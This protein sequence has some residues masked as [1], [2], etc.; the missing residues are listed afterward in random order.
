MT[1]VGAETE[2]NKNID[3]TKYWYCFA[4]AIKFSQFSIGSIL[5]HIIAFNSQQSIRRTKR[6]SFS[7]YYWLISLF[8]FLLLLFH[9]TIKICSK[10]IKIKFKNSNY[11][12]WQLCKD[13]AW[14]TQLIS[15]KFGLRFVSLG[16]QLVETASLLFYNFVKYNYFKIFII[17]IT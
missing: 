13:K 12:V 15:E 7:W 5:I 8:I 4:H 2:S 14:A 17:L 3:T 9:I 1:H 10:F 11:Y 16:L 6:L